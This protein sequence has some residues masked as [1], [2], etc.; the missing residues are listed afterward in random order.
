MLC[1]FF[2]RHFVPGHGRSRRNHQDLLLLLPLMTIGHEAGHYC[3]FK[4]LR[5]FNTDTGRKKKKERKKERRRRKKKKKKEKKKEFWSLLW[6]IS[7]P[8][9][10]PTVIA[11]PVFPSTC[12]PGQGPK[13]KIMLSAMR[14]LHVPH[15]LPVRP[16][17]VLSSLFQRKV[18]HSFTV[19]V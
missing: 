4:R 16:Q 1:P 2:R 5:S 11:L 9:L 12:M 14:I 19:I 3:H 18:F 15:A 7:V 8:H 13:S 17:N 10:D 6:G